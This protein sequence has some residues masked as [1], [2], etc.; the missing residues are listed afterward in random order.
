MPLSAISSM[1]MRQVLAELVEAYGPQEA[2]ALE[3]AGGV[4]VLRRI[5]AGEAFDVVVLARE[6]IDRLAAGGRVDPASRVDL[7][8]SRAALAVRAG[9][10]HPRIDTGAAVRDA[11]AGARVAYSTGPSGRHLLR[12][13]ERWGIAPRLVEAPPGIP[14]ARLLACGEADIGM[15]QASELLGQPGIAVIGVLPPEIEEVTVFAG[16]V[17]SASA[18]RDGA[19]GFLAHCASPA[20]AAA[21]RRHGMEA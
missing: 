2:I 7:A 11:L 12:L 10:P 6:A 1:A 4:D 13:V 19:T 20:A 16:A 15:Q 3:A 14:V 21:K 8:R 9:A 17:G 5:E 18:R